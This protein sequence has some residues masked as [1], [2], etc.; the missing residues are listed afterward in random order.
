[1]EE[2]SD[3]HVPSPSAWPLVLAAS[4]LL[5]A[6]GVVTNFLISLVGIIVL[7]TAIAGWTMENRTTEP[8]HE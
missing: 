6:I 4:F 7:L 3:I 1:M 8:H 2:H 5:I